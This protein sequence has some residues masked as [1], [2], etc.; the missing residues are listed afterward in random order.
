[1]M[2]FIFLIEALLRENSVSKL[3]SA[4]HQKK[5]LWGDSHIVQDIGTHKVSWKGVS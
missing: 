4:G 3:Y 1:M 5:K 2:P